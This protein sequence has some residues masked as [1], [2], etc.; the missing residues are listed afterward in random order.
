[1]RFGEARAHHV[2]GN[3]SPR[4]FARRALRVRNDAA[5]A[6]RVRGFTGRARATGIRCNVDDSA[7]DKT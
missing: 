2:Q 6:R 1:M 7:G 3:T 4:Q 5:L